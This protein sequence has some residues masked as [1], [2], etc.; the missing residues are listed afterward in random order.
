MSVEINQP[1]AAASLGPVAERQRLNAADRAL[2]AVNHA[3]R[4]QGAAGFETQMFV[5][6]DGRVSADGLRV[7]I[8]RLARQ[9]PVIAAR[10]VEDEEQGGPFWQFRPAAHCALQEQMLDSAETQAVLDR[11][12]R[13]LSTPIDLDR[14]D[15]IR[16]HL[17]HRPDGRDVLLVQYNHTLMDNRAALA[18]L[19][20]IDRCYRVGPNDADVAG[21]QQPDLIRTYLRQRSLERR[22]TAAAGAADLWNS[23]VR[24]GATMLGRPTPPAGSQP[25][26]LRIITRQLEPP[27]SSAL[28]SRVLAT[29]GIPNM[30]M[31]VLSSVFR[32]MRRWPAVGN[33]GGNF[34]A[35]IGVD[36]GLRGRNRPVFHN[37]MSMVPIQ[38][39]G[40]SLDDRQ[41][42]LRALSRQFRD[43]VESEMDLGV[44][45]LMSLFSRRPR[46]ARWV[47]DALT[48]RG[49][50]LWYGYFG[51][52]DAAGERFCDTAIERVFYA[53]PAWSP[54][55]L[56]LI[57][58][59]F[60]GRLLLQMTYIPASVPD[61]LASELLDD[62]IADLIG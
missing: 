52:Q 30:S 42:L 21:V 58:N 57:A 26:P 56:S 4:D 9:Y 41:E 35:G 61:A 60:R 20:E 3:L 8:A 62:V 2:L 44:L 13:L 33:G 14:A 28:Q 18:V 46:H 51:P 23:L 25:L 12:A 27:E 47:I 32:A 19:R 38:A 55:G 45:Q 5:W 1:S 43:R 53:G 48:R 54:M 37:L 36:M 29:C 15:P 11:A 17:L 40:Q 49:F 7:A 10:L 24:G 16:F 50:S 6:L 59:Q 31:A 34:I 22:T 39:G